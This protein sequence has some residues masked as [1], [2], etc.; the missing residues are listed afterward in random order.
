MCSSDLEAT[1]PNTTSDPRVF[2]KDA[3]S[4]Y[5][6]QI[7]SGSQGIDLS[8]ADVLIFLNLNFSAMHYL[9]SRARLQTKTRTK[10]AVAHYLCAE[11][12]IEEKILQTVQRKEDY[13]LAHF[14]NE[15]R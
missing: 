10:P 15:Y 5:I 6:S 11:N 9:Q 2:A 8:A 12:G 13:T 4:V 14:M 7:Q 1:I 3:K